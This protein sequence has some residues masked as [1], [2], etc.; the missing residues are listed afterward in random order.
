[1]TAKEK[2]LIKLAIRLIHT[3]DDYY[4]GMNILWKLIGEKP[5]DL[6]LK[7]VSIKDIHNGPVGPFQ[8]PL[9]SLLPDND[10]RPVGFNYKN[11]QQ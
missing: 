11:K 1:M 4:G 9:Q 8:D 7:E 2:A 3:E 5:L 10:S 6:N